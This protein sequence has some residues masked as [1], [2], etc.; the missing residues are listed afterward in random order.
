MKHLFLRCLPLFF[1][2]S[3]CHKAGNVEKSPDVKVIKAK[4]IIAPLNREYIGVL[5][6]IQ[7][8][9]LRARVEGFLDERLFKEGNVVHQG[10]ILYVIDK[11]PFQA[12]LLT[13]E[14]N[15]KKAQ[16]DLVYQE[17]QLRRYAQLVKHQNVSKSNYDQQLASFQAAQGNL[18]SAQGSY[19]QAKLN[20]GYCDVISP[21][22]GLAGKSYVDIGNLVSGANKT[23]LVKVVQLDPIRVEFNPSVS[24]INLFLKYKQFKPFQTLVNLPDAKDQKWTGIVDFYDNIANVSTSTMLLRTTIRNADLLLRP[25][26]YVNIKVT[27]DPKHPFKLIPINKMLEVQGVRQVQVVGK[28]KKL[29]WRAITIGDVHEKWVEVLDG[30]DKDDLIVDDNSVKL[31]EESLVNPI[32]TQ[33]NTKQA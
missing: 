8:V 14:G 33:T 17:L 12:Q 28:D 3:A 15:L 5:K 20:L 32:L 22:N 13:A 19:E 4:E 2:L 27:L 24:D 6:S 1:S 11:A 26:I 16:A 10:D 29:Y 18:E 23:E 31:Q 25:D 7:D 9:T 21:L 30:L